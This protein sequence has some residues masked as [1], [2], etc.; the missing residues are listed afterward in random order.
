MTYH[1][2]HAV[3]DQFIGD[4]L[5]LARVARVIADDQHQALGPVMGPAKPT[6]ISACKGETDTSMTMTSLSMAFPLFIDLPPFP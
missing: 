3:S 1:Q 5:R 6:R 4:R 2:R